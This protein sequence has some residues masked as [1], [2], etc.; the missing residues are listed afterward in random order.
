MAR[1]ARVA[2]RPVAVREARVPHDQRGLQVIIRSRGEDELAECV[3]I[4]AEVHRRD[5]YPMAWPQDPGGFLAKPD[6][7]GAWVAIVDGRLAGHVVLA[8]PKATDVAAA[9]VGGDAAM[10]SRLF[11]TF[12]A[13]G[14]GV[15]AALL[16]HAVQEAHQRGL[17]PVLDVLATSSAPIAFYERMGWRLLGTGQAQWGQNRVT[18][19]G[20]AGP[21][22]VPSATPPPAGSPSATPA[23]GGSPSGAAASGGS[24]SEAAAPAGSPPATPAPGGS[25]SGVPSPAV[26]P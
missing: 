11:V 24:P 16:E 14:R 13:R 5:G 19:R 4:L 20:Y 7:L 15:G 6:F 18:V 22:P 26:D 12:A 8:P 25:P 17:C 23:P 2:A 9:L 3:A 10:V 1:V 21:G